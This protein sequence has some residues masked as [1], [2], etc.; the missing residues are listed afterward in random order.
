MELPWMIG[1]ATMNARR[2]WMK[3]LIDIN[4][5]G[6]KPANITDKV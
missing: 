1:D 2:S 4:I 6:I 5:G 3:T